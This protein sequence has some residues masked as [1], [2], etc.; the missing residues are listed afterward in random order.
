MRE[1]NLIKQ[2]EK[3]YKRNFNNKL[4]PSEY[5][6]RVFLSAKNKKK[7]GFKKYK[8]FKILDLSF[9]DGRNLQFFH[10]LG[11]KVFGTEISKKIINYSRKKK[12]KLNVGKAN[13]LP[14]DNGF[15]DYIVASNSC[16]YLDEN[17]TFKDNLNEISRVLKKNGFFVGNVPHISNYYLKYSIQLDKNEY[18]IKN[19]YLKIR[20]NYAIAAFENKFDLKNILKKN[21]KNIKTG[22]LDNDY[23]GVEEKMFLFVSTKK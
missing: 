22:M 7:F 17:F 10:D 18:L 20:N 6:V 2:Y 11:F 4:Y 9:G 15:F 12:F 14:Y 1:Q 3:Y 5:L 8:D 21:F 19:D 23:F 13:L 16:Y